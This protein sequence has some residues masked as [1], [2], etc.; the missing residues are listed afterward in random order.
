MVIQDCKNKKNDFLCDVERLLSQSKK[1][2]CLTNVIC[3]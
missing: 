1:N 3:Y 2:N